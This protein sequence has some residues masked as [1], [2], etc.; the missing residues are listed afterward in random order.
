M[1]HRHR[2]DRQELRVRCSRWWAVSVTHGVTDRR[3]PRCGGGSAPEQAS[4]CR[5]VPLGGMIR[6]GHRDDHGRRD[7]GDD[8]VDLDQ[9]AHAVGATPVVG[10]SGSRRVH[11]RGHGVPLGGGEVTLRCTDFQSRLNEGIC[12]GDAPHHGVV[13]GMRPSAPR[14]GATAGRWGNSPRTVSTAGGAR[15][16]GCVGR[17]RSPG[18]PSGRGSRRVRRSAGWIAHSRSMTRQVLFD[19]GAGAWSPPG[20]LGSFGGDHRFRSAA[21]VVLGCRHGLRG[22][23]RTLA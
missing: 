22:L 20:R 11:R 5:E 23:G 10:G 6:G 2:R 15:T 3:A 1:R 7:R 9:S 13:V 18:H 8:Q 19:P 21:P 14:P 4:E 17:R 12:S 16:L